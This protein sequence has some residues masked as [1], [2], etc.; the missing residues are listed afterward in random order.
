LK[1]L[2]KLTFDK[3]SKQVC[4][5]ILQSSWNQF[6]GNPETDPTFGP[7]ASATS[8]AN[9]SSTFPLPEPNANAKAPKTWADHQ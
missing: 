4:K 1:A 6:P 7:L 5:A 3:A 9:H 2:L 8:S